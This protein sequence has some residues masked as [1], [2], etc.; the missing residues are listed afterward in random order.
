MLV[1][2]DG[3]L[4]GGSGLAKGHGVGPDSTSLI[5]VLDSIHTVYATVAD[6]QAATSKSWSGRAVIAGRPYRWDAASLVNDSAGYLTIRPTDL[7]TTDPGRWRLESNVV[8]LSLAFTYATADAAVLYT[9]PTGCILQ[10]MSLWWEITAD[11]TGG[12]SSAIG[13]SSNKTGFTAKGCLLG[14]K[15]GDVLASLTAALSPTWGTRGFL[16]VPDS[17]IIQENVAVAT[18]AAT[19]TYAIQQLLYAKTIGTG[20]AG[21]KSALINGA[22]P[23]AGQAAPNA[24]GTSVAFHAETTG[25]GTADLGYLTAA[26]ASIENSF[27]AAA[28]TIRFDRIT[29]VFT[30][31]TGKVH[32]LARVIKIP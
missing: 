14:G 7:G 17:R 4:Q 1:L 5:D 31:G 26:G 22:S 15:T 6:A 23:S 25:T 18:A 8:E 29:S 20:A 24:G 32:V 21:V 28:E 11:F 13:V 19:P 2:P 16:A 27:W 30:A 12:S 9:V 10:I 3:F